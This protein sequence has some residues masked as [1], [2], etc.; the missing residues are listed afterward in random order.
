MLFAGVSDS[1]AN[2]SSEGRHQVVVKRTATKIPNKSSIYLLLYI[3]FS[4]WF[5][6]WLHIKNGVEQTKGSPCESCIFDSTGNANQFSEIRIFDVLIRNFGTAK[7][8]ILI[9]NFL[10][11]LAIPDLVV[12]YI[13]KTSSYRNLTYAHLF[14]LNYIIFK[15][16]LIC[17]LFYILLIYTAQ[18]H[19]LFDGWL[20]KQTNKQINNWS[21]YFQCVHWLSIV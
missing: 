4:Q 14:T 20:H 1:N 16:I 17:L 18:N 21:H 10:W 2:V 8:R 3:S 9:K 19:F 6:N 5:K 12:L 13:W 7:F 15:Q 11:W